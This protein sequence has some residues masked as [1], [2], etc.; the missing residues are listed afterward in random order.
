[1]GF[2]LGNQYTKGKH[3]KCKRGSENRSRAMRGNQNTKGMRGVWK[4][5]EES[6]T[7]ASEKR[8]GKRN[9][10]IHNENIRKGAIKYNTV[11]NFFKNRRYSGTRIELIMK[12]ILKWQRHLEIFPLFRRQYWIQHFK[13]DFCSLKWKI[14]IE[15][16]G[17]FWHSGFARKYKDMKRKE[18]LEKLGY[19]VLVF[20]EDEIYN[21][22]RNPEKFLEIFVRKFLEDKNA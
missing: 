2:P 5:S 10:K 19:R 3:W 11:N 21:L 13:T 9:S 8:K 14:I 7:K 18:I 15:C 1:M 22:E 16:N 4:W 6:K 12:E 17:K 20:N